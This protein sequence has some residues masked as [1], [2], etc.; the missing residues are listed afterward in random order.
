[1]N[2]GANINPD[3]S[4]NTISDDFI[5]R[6]TKDKNIEQSLHTPLLAESD[7]NIIRVKSSKE[8]LKKGF[9]H[10]GTGMYRCSEH[11]IWRIEKEGNEY[12]LIRKQEE[13]N[14]LTANKKSATIYN[15]VEEITY[16]VAD[17]DYSMDI[18]FSPG[19]QVE[20]FQLTDDQYVLV[21]AYGSEIPFTTLG[22]NKL[23]QEGKLRKVGSISKLSLYEVRSNRPDKLIFEG[24]E[25][26]ILD[27]ADDNNLDF[28]VD[29]NI[30][31]VGYF[32][33]ANGI[34]YEIRSIQ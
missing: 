31:C 20:Q 17:P 13:V 32:K 3:N 21:S 5:N 30:K 27:Y 23:L 28:I 2:K 25:E 19:E 4:F 14:K 9:E 15:V 12:K 24:S 6:I 22:L 18:V 1:M 11:H 8:L 26:Q 16:H 34:R 10:L 29:E 7:K 33:S